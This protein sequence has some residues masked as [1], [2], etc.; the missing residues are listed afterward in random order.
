MANIDNK[1]FE[2]C[3]NPDIKKLDILICENFIQSAGEPAKEGSV[4]VETLDLDNDSP[5]KVLLALYE[6]CNKEKKV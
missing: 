3:K 2:D 5:R 6:H 1:I 4:R